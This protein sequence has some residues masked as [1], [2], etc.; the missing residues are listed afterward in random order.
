M[1]CLCTCFAYSVSA[2]L[3]IL[4]EQDRESW[5]YVKRD[6]RFPSHFWIKLDTFKSL[7]DLAYWSEDMFFFSF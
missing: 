3:Y 2:C 4:L 6:K 1:I 5:S 7:P